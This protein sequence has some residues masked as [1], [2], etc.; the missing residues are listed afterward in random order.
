MCISLSERLT[1]THLCP[2]DRCDLTLFRPRHYEYLTRL[3]DAQPPDRAYSNV[4]IA[5][6]AGSW[7]LR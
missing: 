2:Y 3:L 1:I 4:K 5:A 7:L 6:K